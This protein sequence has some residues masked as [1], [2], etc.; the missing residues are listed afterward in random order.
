ML[1]TLDHLHRNGSEGVAPLSRVHL[2]QNLDILPE[3]RYKSASGAPG[4]YLLA[5]SG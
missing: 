1:F 2:A 4:A 5:D 3:S